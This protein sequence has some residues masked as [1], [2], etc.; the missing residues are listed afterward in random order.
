MDRSWNCLRRESRCEA[1]ACYQIKIFSCLV[2]PN[3]SIPDIVV[4]KMPDGDLCANAG[5][6]AFVELKQSVRWAITSFLT[7]FFE[8][9]FSDVPGTQPLTL[10]PQKHKLRSHVEDSEVP[11]EFQ[12]ID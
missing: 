11:V 5:M 8:N 7:V 4:S 9:D 6:I 1:G 10:Q 3:R 12:T 2:R